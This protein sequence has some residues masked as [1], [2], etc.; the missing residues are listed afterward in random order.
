MHHGHRPAGHGRTVRGSPAGGPAS[1]TWRWAA[2]AIATVSTFAGAHAAG[3][4]STTRPV[5]RP[6][7]RKGARPARVSAAATPAL[8]SAGNGITPATP[9]A[10]I[11]ADTAHGDITPG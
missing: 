8:D 11:T 9:P 2:L 4:Q 7:A 6:V 5:T 1:A 10:T 3:A